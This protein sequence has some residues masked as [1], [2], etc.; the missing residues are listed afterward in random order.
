MLKPN[1]K[2]FGDKNMPRCMLILLCSI[3]LMDL[4][5][6]LMLNLHSKPHIWDSQKKKLKSKSKSFS[7]LLR[8][9]SS[10]DTVKKS[11]QC[12]KILLKIKISQFLLFILKPDTSLLVPKD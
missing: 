7:L 1:S 9:H 11:I 10:Q 5:A 2:D 8:F 4:M 3:I 6:H 12:S